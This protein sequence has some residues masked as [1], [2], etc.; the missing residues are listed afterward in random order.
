MKDIPDMHIPKEER[1]PRWALDKGAELERDNSGLY[2]EMS[3][4]IGFKIYFFPKFKVEFIKSFP[5][6]PNHKGKKKAKEESAP[7]KKKEK[8][9]VKKIEF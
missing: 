1:M 8:K 6:L 3:F 7:K 4:N 2:Y 5:V 9:E